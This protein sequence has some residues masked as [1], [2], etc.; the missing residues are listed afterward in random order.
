MTSSVLAPLL[1]M[2]AVAMAISLLLAGFRESRNPALTYWALSLLLAPAGWLAYR[3]HQSLDGMSV[4]ILG[5]SVVAT[6]FALQ[7]CALAS[8]SQPRE[9]LPRWVIAIPLAVVVL[10]LG[11]WW[12]WPQRPLGSGMLSVIGSWM[13]LVCAAKAQQLDRGR[14]GMA[15]GRILALNFCAVGVILMLRAALL[16]LPSGTL[17][18]APVAATLSRDWLIAFVVLAPIIGTLNLALVERDQLTRRYRQLANQDG[19]TG[20]ATRRH[21]LEQGQ[22]LF[23][24]AREQL[25]ALAVLMI[26]IDRFK[27]IND[28]YGHD[29]G[30][31]VLRQVSGSIRRALRRVDVAGRT[32]GEEFVAILPGASLDDALIIGERVRRHVADSQCRCSGGPVQTTVSVGCAVR[33][34]GDQS[35]ECL[36]RRADQAMYSAKHNGRN[37][38]SHTHRQ[39]ATVTTLERT[40]ERGESPALATADHQ[41]S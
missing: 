9:P 3:T 23:Q 37:Q 29:C 21:L 22:L 38:V 17:F 32:G 20:V 19:L 39:L 28:R 40:A 8:L 25:Q 11:H 5:K 26:D 15:H 10:C 14:E 16:L 4:A 2:A 31:E 41:Q 18:A 34:S 24:Q 27:D 6:A 12:M 30:D 13:A 36:L 1:S 33:Q 35:L 7:Y